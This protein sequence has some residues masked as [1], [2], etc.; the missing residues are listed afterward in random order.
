MPG[1]VPDTFTCI[2]SLFNPTRNQLKI[3]VMHRR[4]K[5]FVFHSILFSF[6]YNKWP[7][8]NGST[9]KK[10]LHFPHPVKLIILRIEVLS[11]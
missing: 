2:L 5:A 9:E 8:T 10:I 7:K 4:D 1:T 11:Y 3:S 6:I